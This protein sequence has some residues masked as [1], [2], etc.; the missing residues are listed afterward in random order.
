[1]QKVNLL[2]RQERFTK[3]ENVVNASF[4]GISGLAPSAACSSA[5][6]VRTDLFNRNVFVPSKADD[7]FVS[8]GGSTVNIDGKIYQALGSTPAEFISKVVVTA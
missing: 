3:P 1:M 7:S 2:E 5:G 4:C 8:G 6:L